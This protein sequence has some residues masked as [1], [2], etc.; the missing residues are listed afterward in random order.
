MSRSLGLSNLA[1]GLDSSGSITYIN[2]SSTLTSND[3]QSAIDELDIN[4]VERTSITGSA[5]IPAGTELERDSSPQE[6]YF[7]FNTDTSQFEGYN[8]AEWGEIGG[9]GGA[10]GGGNDQVF[11]EN[12][13][14]VTTNY[15]IGA[16][17]NALTTGP[18]E[19]NS[20]VVITVPDGS[21]WVIL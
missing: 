16:G 18:V 1:K 10:T 6:G 9:G 5:E 12:D 7:R 15:E 21:R 11:I 3:I 14:V 19:V 2:D 13:Q 17:R 20:G 4:K 8:G